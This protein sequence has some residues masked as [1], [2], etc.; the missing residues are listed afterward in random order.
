VGADIAL[1]DSADLELL[2]LLADFEEAAADEDLEAL[3]EAALEELFALAAD[4][5]EA[6]ALEELEELEELAEFDVLTELSFFT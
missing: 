2:F 3:D 5:E 6:L 1:E 4:F